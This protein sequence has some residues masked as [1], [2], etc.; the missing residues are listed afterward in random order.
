MECHEYGSYNYPETDSES[1]SEVG[2]VAVAPFA[3]SQHFDLDQST[4]ASTGES[5]EAGSVDC[6]PFVLRDEDELTSVSDFDSE[7]RDKLECDHSDGDGST[8]DESTAE[9]SHEALAAHDEADE[10]A[11]HLWPRMMETVS[12]A[13]VDQSQMPRIETAPG[14]RSAC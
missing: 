13:S 5:T 10:H 2:D 11:D 7:D 4:V 12:R 8:K 9:L 6:D 1:E 3:P 14:T